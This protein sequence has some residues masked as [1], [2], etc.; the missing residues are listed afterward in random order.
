MGVLMSRGWKSR[1]HQVN[2]ATQT[3]LTKANLVIWQISEKL[4]LCVQTTCQTICSSDHAVFVLAN[5]KTSHRRHLQRLWQRTFEVKRQCGTVCNDNVTLRQPTALSSTFT[6]LRMNNTTA[7]PLYECP[8]N[9]TLY[10]GRKNVSS[11]DREY[12]SLMKTSFG[13][14]ASLSF[15]GNLLLCLVMFRKRAMLQKPY[16]VLICSLAITDTLTGMNANKKI[17]K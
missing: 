4:P 16:N 2:T 17:N 6:K 1:Y 9:N 10:L 15:F 14:I 8:E 3:W 7:C 5:Q 13:L 12:G 11:Q